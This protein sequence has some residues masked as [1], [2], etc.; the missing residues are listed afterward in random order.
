VGRKERGEILHSADVIGDA[1]PVRASAIRL[2][3]WCV[4]KPRR[5]G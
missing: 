5:E 2:P 3:A 4:L 1:R